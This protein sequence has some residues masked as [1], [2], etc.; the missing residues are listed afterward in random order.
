MRQRRAIVGGA[1]ALLCY[2]CLPNQQRQARRNIHIFFTMML[3]LVVVLVGCC[4]LPL[5]FITTHEFPFT[6]IV[7]IL[8]DFYSPQHTLHSL[9]LCRSRRCCCCCAHF[10]GTQIST[11]A[12]FKCRQM[13]EPFVQYNLMCVCCVCI[14][15]LCATERLCICV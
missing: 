9:F 10:A 7:A 2:I 1:A 11:T 12:L 4:W 15:R 3:C 8:L 5:A 14:L 6:V 13:K